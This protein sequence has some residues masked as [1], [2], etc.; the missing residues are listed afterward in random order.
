MSDLTLKF[1]N[2]YLKLSADWEGRQATL[3]SVHNILLQYQSPAFLKYDTCYWKSREKKEK[4]WYE[5]PPEGEYLLL[6]F[7]MS[8]GYPQHEQAPV[9]T[10]LRRWTHEKEE[11]YR[12]NKGKFFTLV[13]EGERT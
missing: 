8:G 9:F 11:Y 13:R 6:L 3:L 7:E 5:L 1:S 12:S 10:T 4:G 2:D